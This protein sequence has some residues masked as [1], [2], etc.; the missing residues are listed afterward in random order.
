MIQILIAFLLALAPV[1]SHAR[2]CEQDVVET[3]AREDF[4]A[5]N[6][7]GNM[8][9]PQINS[10]I[11]IAS[12]IQYFK[13][14][15]PLK[16]LLKKTSREELDQFAEQMNRVHQAYG[17]DY[18]TRNFPTTRPAQLVTLKR[19]RRVADG[20]SDTF[21]YTLVTTLHL[22]LPN[23]PFKNDIR[24][25]RLRR[26]LSIEEYYEMVDRLEGSYDVRGSSETPAKSDLPLA[27]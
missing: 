24:K 4:F 27:S 7:Y 2:S 14:P 12:L 20:G 6:L 25:F 19:L 26:T 9:F 17:I 18:A 8:R 21:I 10:G 16:Q 11:R 5:A 13:R 22:C 3:S 15:V 23:G 1:I